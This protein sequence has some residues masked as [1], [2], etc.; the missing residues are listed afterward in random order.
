MAHERHAP[1]HD[2]DGKIFR[3]GHSL[4]DPVG[5]ILDNQYSDIDT[6]RQPRI[7]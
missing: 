4:N 2:V 1:K 5:R 3:N 6:S 7:L